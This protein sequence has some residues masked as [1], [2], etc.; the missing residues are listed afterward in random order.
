MT[1]QINVNVVVTCQIN[2][3]FAILKFKTRHLFYKDI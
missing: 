2:A 3:D 1:C